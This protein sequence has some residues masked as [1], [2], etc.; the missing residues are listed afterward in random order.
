MPKIRNKITGEIIEIPDTGRVVATAPP[1]PKAPVG[2]MPGPDPTVASG[3]VEGQG[4]IAAAEAG[5]RE[6]AQRATIAFQTQQ[7]IAEAAAK[8]NISQK[9]EAAKALAL[10]PQKL[11]NIRAAQAQID[12]LTGLFMKG[13]GATKGV[14]GLFDYLPS[15]AN[16]QFDTAGAGLGDTA[17]AAFRTPGSGTQSDADLR[18]FIAA[19]RPSASDFDSAIKEKIS[20]MQNR[21]DQTYSAY[22]MKRQMAKK[23]PAKTINFNDLPE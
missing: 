7:A 20:N 11:A 13:P 14:S 2:Y 22:G 17:F 5:A 18:A 16:K 1:M 9:G 8:A 12:R 4:R 3:Y 6:A 19:N 15:P 21:L 10:D 23:A